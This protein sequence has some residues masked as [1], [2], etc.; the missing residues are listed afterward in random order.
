MPPLLTRELYVRA[1]RLKRDEVPS[2]D[3][4][5]FS[6][7]AVRTITELPFTRPI[8]I[9]VGENGLGKSTLIE[10]I[11]VAYGFNPEGGS[12]NFNFETRASHSDLC[13]YVRL[14]KS[15]TRPRDGW[16]L[17]SESYF[18]VATEIERLDREPVNAPAIIEAYGGQPL[19][20]QSHG[21]SF[22]SLVMKRMRGKGFY[23]F[24]EPESALS[25]MRQLALLARMRQLV[26]AESQ[27]IIATHSPI[28]MGC[29]D[30][31][32]LLLDEAGIRPVAWR[33]TEHYVV[34]R[35]FLE[36]PEGMLEELLEGGGSATDSPSR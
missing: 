19:H 6:L 27:F 33:D 31:E 7:A 10:A 26:E 15:W 14:V 22:L 32:I 18:N 3:A 8:T 9:L 12:K 36:D 5:P 23:V 25:P 4:Y 30:A 1:L 2:F 13:D 24:D 34:A 17:R 21:E 11:A 28:L 20:E 35:A 29:P 16:F